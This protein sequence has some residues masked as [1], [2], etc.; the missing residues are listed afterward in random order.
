MDF[1][2]DLVKTFTDKAREV[3][4]VVS[5]IRNMQEAFGYAVE[6]CTRRGPGGREGAA[7]CQRIIAAPGLEKAHLRQFGELCHSAGITLIASGMRDHPDG[8]EL[9]FTV[10][11]YGIAET[12][13]VVLDSAGEE[14][15]LA[16]ML[17]E[18]HVAVLAK[19]AIRPDSFGLESELERRMQS[20]GDYTAFITGASRTADIE[21]VLALGVHGPLELHILL[22]EEDPCSKP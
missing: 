3:S 17:S 7:A 14:L 22:L 20:S 2:E 6:L 13:T 9:G 21:R 19:A 4:A 15:R 18:V 16:T 1:P 10:A 12:G 8:V 5:G 11:D